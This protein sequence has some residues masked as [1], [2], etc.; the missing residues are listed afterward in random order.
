[1]CAWAS[2]SQ[3]LPHNSATLQLQVLI[4]MQMDAEFEKEQIG[5]FFVWL[6]PVVGPLGGGSE[7]SQNLHMPSFRIFFTLLPVQVISERSVLNAVVLLRYVANAQ[8]MCNCLMCCS[9][10]GV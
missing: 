4:R 2:T 7:A 6:G 9:Y 5:T 10:S 8:L 1:M 3:F